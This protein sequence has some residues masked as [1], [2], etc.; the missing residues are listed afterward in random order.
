MTEEEMRRYRYLRKEIAVER[1]RMA[2]MAGDERARRIAEIIA[3]KIERAETEAERIERFIAD[4]EE[5]AVRMLMVERYIHGRSWRAAGQRIG[6]RSED[7]ARKTVKR[8]FKKT[9]NGRK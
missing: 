6:W 4:V 1:E 8:Y 3:E 2:K 9:G 5:P 7:A